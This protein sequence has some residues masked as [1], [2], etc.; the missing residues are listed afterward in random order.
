VIGFLTSMIAHWLAAS[1][2]TLE[3]MQAVLDTNFWLATHV[4]TVTF[5]YSATF[6][7]GFF[8]IVFLW[9]M[10]VTH[11][12]SSVREGGPLGAGSRALFVVCAVAACA[13]VALLFVGILFG[14]WYGSGQRA[15]MR[16]LVYGASYVAVLGTPLAIL[17][18]VWHRFRQAGGAAPAGLPR[19]TQ[20]L[21]SFALTEHTRRV[22]VWMMYG[23]VCFAMLFSFV[24]TVLGGIWA[25]Y[26]WG[27][28]WG[29]DPK[30][31]GAILVVIWNALILHARW[32]GM[33]KPR[34]MAVLA[35]LG[36][37]VTTWSWFGTNQL[38]V[39][40]HAYGFR[41][42][43]ALWVVISSFAFATIALAGL[44]PTKAW[45]SYGTPPA[46]EGAKGRD[47]RTAK[48][49]AAT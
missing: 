38:G 15:S 44:V 3:M 36:N 14:L 28:F 4:T 23:T 42:D 29:W 43:I 37:I 5:G 12:L 17:Y 6:V 1:G 24:G 19:G 31:N 27:R 46:K 9:M 47:R 39:G 32:A 41:N 13:F 34:G 45:M 35:V 11:M 22:L 21:E 25:D 7:A 16:F 20:F 2:D 30:E 33:I 26:S 48:A 10:L 18:L 49:A 8:G 40:L